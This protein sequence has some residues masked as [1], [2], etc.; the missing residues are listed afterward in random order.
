VTPIANPNGED[1]ATSAGAGLG[2]LVD[3]TGSAGSGLSG[4]G[5]SD[6]FAITTGNMNGGNGVLGGGMGGGMGGGTSASAAAGFGGGSPTSALASRR[7]SRAQNSSGTLKASTGL[8][9]ALF[10]MAALML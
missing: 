8:F 10:V 9:G 7:Q 3:M 5:Q 2:S 6:P 4:A 1:S